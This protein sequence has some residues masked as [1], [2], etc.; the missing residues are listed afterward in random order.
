[1]DTSLKKTT[2]LQT[3][4][5]HCDLRRWTER[6]T[7]QWLFTHNTGLTWWLAVRWPRF[8]QLTRSHADW[9]MMECDENTSR[10][11]QQSDRMAASNWSVGV[12]SWAS[13]VRLG[14]QEAFRS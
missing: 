14:W 2:E 11:R 13:W 6:H 5:N 12:F 4:R 1:M 7:D 9:L 10:N 8:C 3:N